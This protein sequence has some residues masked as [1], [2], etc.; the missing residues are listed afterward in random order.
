MRLLLAYAVAVFLSGVVAFI[1][2]AILGVVAI[3]ATPSVFNFPVPDPPDSVDFGRGIL[4]M[5][6][7]LSVFGT[8][9]VPLWVVGFTYLR[10]KY[11]VDSFIA[12]DAVRN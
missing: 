11:D 9:L 6:V 1:V 5:L 3:F 2:A 8:L 7:G 4:M 12:N 10:K